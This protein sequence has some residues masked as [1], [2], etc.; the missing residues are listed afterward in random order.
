[1]GPGPR[2]PNEGKETR[3]KAGLRGREATNI[4][5]RPWHYCHVHGILVLGQRAPGK[6]TACRAPTSRG[7]VKAVFAEALG[8]EVEVDLVQ[9]VGRGQAP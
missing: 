8:E 7:W 4:R 5:Q 1:V 2:K 9:A 3:D 6:G